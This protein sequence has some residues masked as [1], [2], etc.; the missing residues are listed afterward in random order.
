MT[1]PRTLLHEI[2]AEWLDALRRTGAQS[3]AVEAPWRA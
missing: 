1:D 3:V 2:V